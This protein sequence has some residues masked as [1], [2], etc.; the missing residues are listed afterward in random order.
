MAALPL[1]WVSPHAVNPSFSCP[2]LPSSAFLR[3]RAPTITVCCPASCGRDWVRA[4]QMCDAFFP[5]PAEV[6]SA[7]AKAAALAP[8]LACTQHPNQALQP[9][10]CP[11]LHTVFT[12]QSG[13]ASW[14][15][16]RAIQTLSPF[17]SQQLSSNAQ[18]FHW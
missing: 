7:A 5:S 17:P 13:L 8:V 11:S 6:V 12:L 2:L 14:H 16:G 1:W 4:A 9:R 3:L 10:R 15:W 18:V